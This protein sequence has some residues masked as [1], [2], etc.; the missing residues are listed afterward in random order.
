MYRMHNSRVRLATLLLLV[1]G[2]FAFVPARGAAPLAG[3]NDF[4][5]GLGT[6]T[7]VTSYG[8]GQSGRLKN[9]A[10]G[11]N[12]PFS[13]TVTGTSLSGAVQGRPDYGSPA[14]IVFDGIVDLA[15]FPSPAL[16]LAATNALVYTF[17]GLN[18]NAEYN[19]QGTA[20][21][22]N[23]AY[24]VNRWSVFEI[25]NAVSFASQHTAGALTSAQLSTLT[26]AQVAIATGD[27]AR[28]DLA[29]WEHIRPSASG[30]FSV[31]SRQYTNSLPSGGTANGSRGY[32]ITGFRLEEAPVYSGRTN[33]PPRI[34]GHSDGGINGIKT[35][36]IVI[37]EN[38]DWST[39]KDSPNCPYIN[40]TL[41]PQGAWSEQYF[42]PP[43]IHPSLPNYLWLIS[44][45]NFGIRDD[46]NPSA[47][48]QSSTQTLFHQLDAA[49]ISW[50]CYG[51]GVTGTNIQDVN[52]G[53]YAVRH[54]PFM[55]FDTVRNNLNYCTNHIRPF[56]E[57]GRDLTNGNVAR[58][59]F[60]VPNT[61]NDMH[62]LT[63][64]SA[65]TRIQGD[66]WLS[67][68]MPQILTSTAYTNGGLL[69]V[70][71]D[72][73]EGSTGDGPIGTIFVSPR[74]KRPGYSNNIFYDHSSLLRTF[75]DLYGLSPYLGGAAFANDMS[76]LFQT[77]SIS[78]I[79]RD[80]GGSHVMATNLIV[81]KTAVLQFATNV[82]S[83]LW[84]SV[85]TAVS[86]N[87][88]Q[89]FNDTRTGLP[90]S[91]IYRLREIQ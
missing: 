73:G 54:V 35:V 17:T 50:K 42:N 89:P 4:V 5:T 53:Q 65:S 29:W 23:L 70:A 71:F 80:T 75:Q 13:V 83:P 1:L 11:A 56:S 33:P 21:R 90:D 14:S 67:L 68:Q 43:S 37:M 72:E 48:H 81:G 88:S 46:A 16:E 63:P 12:L 51:E 3:F 60:L 87:T 61:T 79:T 82:V 8:P 57:L 74:V 18:P 38:H 59:N 34:P 77:L 58:F 49:G 32:A 6:G 66:T 91:G 62:D 19:F 36:W 30:T 52:S 28:G 64:G 86:T 9:I 7:N 10:T 44:G 78:K 15:G 20:I 69:V 31:I 27:N 26:A 84:Q 41:L 45:T 22:G 47:N 39:I 24:G 2:G 76:D 40:N 85:R 25:S 55:Y